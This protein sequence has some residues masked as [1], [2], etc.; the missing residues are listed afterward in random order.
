[1]PNRFYLIFEAAAA[2][3]SISFLSM[4]AYPQDGNVRIEWKVENENGIKNY[5]VEYSSDGI[6]FSNIGVEK[7]K[8]GVANS[9]AFIHHQPKTGNNFYRIEVIKTNGEVEYEKVVKVCLPESMPAIRIYPNP[10]TGS[11]IK[12]QF[13]NQPSGKYYFNLY[14][15]IGQKMF[16]KEFNYEGGNSIQS[17]RPGKNFIQGIYHLEIIKPTGD[18]RTLK[19]WK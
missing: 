15:S 18:R 8:N 13:R 17:L 7:P 9:Y 3:L 12:L 14:N 1:M 2:P 10:V 5:L 11:I 4:N 6:H 19:V 16:S